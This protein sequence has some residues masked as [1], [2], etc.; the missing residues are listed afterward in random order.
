MR[1]VI[2][3]LI[4]IFCEAQLWTLD[5]C[6]D[7]A[8]VNN[9][10]LK[11]SQLNT[12][13][14]YVNLKDSKNNLLPT[15]NGH[16][17]QGYNWG[18]TIDLFT[19]QFATNRVKYNNF[20]LSSSLV[21]FSGLQKHYSIRANNINVEQSN[22]D[23]K[24]ARRNIKIDVSAAFL[25]VLLNMEI[26]SSSEENLTK[27][28]QDMERIEVLLLAN[29]ATN[30]DK[31]EVETQLLEDNYKLLKAKND[32]NFSLLLL[33]QLLNISPSIDFEVFDSFELEFNPVLSLDD[34]TA[35]KLPE[36]LINN[37]EI[38]KQTF[39]LKSTKGRYYPSLAINGFI[40][41]GYSENNK[42]LLSNGEFV[43]KPLSQQMN[44][45]L[46]QSVQLTMSIP[47]FNR[48]S[49]RNQVKINELELESLAISKQIEYNQLKQELEKLWLDIQNIALQLD[50]LEI[51]FRKS[52]LNHSNYLVRYL[53]GDINYYQYIDAKNKMF[54]A[55]S[56]WIQ[57]KYKYLFNQVVLGFYFE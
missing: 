7:T 25:Q 57:I 13:V 35:N 22:L 3:L 36:V 12:K 5:Q 50:V 41:S 45:N 23:L 39:L 4:P 19:N 48:N 26:V 28:I 30:Y 55:K 44:E 54:I 21:L 27:T 46:Y 15:L 53:N 37:L 49:V 43:P 16:V 51:I 2:F 6:L 33:Q 20:F 47:L 18:Q 17:S 56:N 9:L 8:I 38:Q 40:G 34:S 32:L 24:I 29:Q 10:Q 31:V 42:M 11:S 1:I 52:E 14:A